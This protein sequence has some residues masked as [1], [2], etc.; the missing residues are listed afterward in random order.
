MKLMVEEPQIEDLHQALRSVE[1]S[2]LMRISSKNSLLEDIAQGN[3]DNWD[4]ETCVTLL[5][6]P[7]GNELHRDTETHSTGKADEDWLDDFLNLD[8]LGILFES[9]S[10]QSKQRTTS[11]SDVLLQLE[12]V[13]CIKAVMNS[14]IGLGHITRD[15]SYTRKLAEA[16]KNNSMMVR[17][18]VFELLSA[19]CMYSERGHALALDALNNYKVYHGLRYRFQLIIDEIKTAEVPEY[20]ACLLAFVNCIVLGE[21]QLP[22]RCAL[23]NEFLGLNLENLLF[24]LRHCDCDAVYV[25]VEV[26]DTNYVED[27]EELLGS[28]ELQLTHNHYEI[29]GTL[30]DKIKDTPQALQLL[31]ILKCLNQM[32]PSKAESD[33]LWHL[34][35]RVCVRSANDI[36]TTTWANSF[37]VEPLK[38]KVSVATQTIPTKLKKKEFQDVKKGDA[39]TQT[40]EKDVSGESI[41]LIPPPPPPPGST[42]PTPPP[43]PLP[44]GGGPPPPPPPPPPPGG[45]PPPP[46][47]PPGGGP[48][49]PPPPPGGGP[50]PP[51]PPPG[52]CPPVSKSVGHALASASIPALTQVLAT[53]LPKPRSKMKRLNWS[54]VT[55][56]GIQNDCV[57]KEIEKD[58]RDLLPSNLNF[59]EIEELFCQRVIVKEENK[60]VQKKNTNAA[61]TLFDPKTSLNVNIFLRQYKCSPDVVAS[62]IKDCDIS[63]I[64]GD[65]LRGLLKIIP[66]DSELEVIKEYKENVA[67]L[68]DPEKFFYH[69]LKI[70]S[71]KTRIEGMILMFEFTPESQAL[72]PQLDKLIHCCEEI[73]HSDGI[74]QFLAYV[75]TLGNFINMGSYA[76]NAPGFKLNTIS[77]LWET[78]ANQAGVTLM[79]YIEEQSRSDKS[80]AL[81]FVNKL[82]EQLHGVDRI[83]IDGI[84]SEV[85]NLSVEVKKIKKKIEN[86]DK[87]FATH[88]N[89]FICDCETTLGDLNSKLTKLEEYRVKLCHYFCEE[90]NKFRLEDCLAIFLILCNKVHEA[91]KENRN[92]HEREQKKKQREEER[93][94]LEKERADLKASGVTLRTKKGFVPPKENEG[95]VVDLLLQEIK[96]G[97]FKLRKSSEEQRGL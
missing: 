49:P 4:P 78:R 50:P 22:L 72:I 8:G 27:Q 24:V 92:R 54:K 33:D 10:R 95:C 63:Q 52:M 89:K 46:P 6:N 16:L 51:P 96:K 77:K 85:Q 62:Y 90:E 1:S 83:S 69:L 12:C 74:K 25:Q 3:L 18:Q 31:T 40:S 28:D 14:E 19:L 37:L 30:F 42:I 34:L 64:G 93:K 41:S 39:S 61:V 15:N 23:R 45:G 68:A 53:H 44:P 66:D 75:L 11:I 81:N 32:D 71:Y 97:N 20:Q 58:I 88:F 80:N 43:P 86:S 29:F 5:K 36:L 79:H 76:G 26:F 67:K 2:K 60:T 87:E 17:Q 35:E 47:P 55:S 94:R 21:S 73:L 13:T 9:L 56:Q 57:W 84:K 70:P 59:E 48:P 65:R 82:G 38:T 7:R 91:E